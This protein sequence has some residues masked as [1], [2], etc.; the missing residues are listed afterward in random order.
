MK[1]ASARGI[2]LAAAIAIAGCATGPTD[3]QRSAAAQAAQMT[4]DAEAGKMD[5]REWARRTEPLLI[6]VNGGGVDAYERAYLAYRHAIAADIADKKIGWE[7]GK[8][9]ILQRFTELNEAK[10]RTAA[11][12]RT[13]RPVTCTRIGYSVTCF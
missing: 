13:N 4:R 1:Y 5:W 6:I 8:A 9:M 3:E 7:Q 2:I 11:L 12:D 10:T